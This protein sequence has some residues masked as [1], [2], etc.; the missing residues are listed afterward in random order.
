M[1][2]RR[3]KEAGRERREQRQEQASYNNRRAGI[4]D[5]RQMHYQFGI[6]LPS[7]SHLIATMRF[8]LETI[9][10]EKCSQKT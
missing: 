2:V 1:I 9:S 8:M 7:S 10:F 3:K 5:K 4:L 6:C